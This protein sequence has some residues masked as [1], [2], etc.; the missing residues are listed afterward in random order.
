MT[1]DTERSV[2]RLIGLVRIGHA[3][4]IERLWRVYF[5]QLVALARKK[6]APATPRL[7]DG[8]DVALRAFAGFWNGARQDR[9]PQLT[10][11]SALWPLLVAITANKCTDLVRR[12]TRGAGATPDPTALQ[13]IISREPAPEFACQLADQLAR[14]F[15]RLDGTGDPTLRRV[16]MLRLNGLTHNEIADELG[17]VRE[18]VSRKLQL[19][20]LCWITEGER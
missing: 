19:I 3:D 7:A 17:S 11:R 16:A 8:E 13:H 4:A 20:E 18:T 12:E 10:D 9:F 15:R 5:H 1:A 6:L 14:L 2:T